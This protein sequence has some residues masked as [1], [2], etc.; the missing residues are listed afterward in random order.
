M[1]HEL[2]D[3]PYAYD[4]LEPHVD[5]MTMEIHHGKHH[6]TYVTKL[7]AALEKHSELADKPVEELI[8]QIGA[9]PSD[10]QTAVRNNGGGHAN[11]AMF[12]QLMSPNGG[13][14]PGGALGDAIGQAFGDFATFQEQF[15]NAAL[16]RFGSGWAW[17]IVDDAGQLAITDTPNQDTPLMRDTAP[18][19]GTPILGVDVWEHAYYLKYQNRRPDYVDAWWNVVNWDEVARRFDAAK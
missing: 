18:K 8:A 10:I 7:N 14:T 3:L 17:L 15:K 12:W 16:G 13:G 1:A 4:A 5:A 9:L 11:H 2:P 19:A 6:N